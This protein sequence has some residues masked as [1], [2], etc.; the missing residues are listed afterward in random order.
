LV[1]EKKWQ[2]YPREK[3][4]LLDQLLL[5]RG[6]KTKADVDLFLNPKLE[7]LIPPLKQFPDMPKVLDRIEK[8]IKQ[9]EPMIIYGDFD[10]DGITGTASLWE[11]LYTFG[12]KVT[13]YIPHRVA[14]GYGLH[15]EAIEKFAQD[16]VKVVIS[17][18]CGITALEEADLAKKLG[19]DLIITDHH[20]PQEKL[21]D[22]FATLHT[23]SLCGS[24]VSWKL[25]W[26]LQEK[27]NPNFN[28]EDILKTI[29]LSAIGTI[30]DMVPLVGENR[31]IVTFG[32]E[33]IKNTHRF[34]LQAMLEEASV[35]KENLRT[36]DIS[37]VIAPRLNS[38]GRLESAMDSLR[39][40][41]T[42][43][44]DRARQ[45][46]H[47]VSQTNQERQKILQEN[48]LHAQEL[49]ATQVDNKIIVLWHESY[50]QGV[51]GLIAGRILEQTG[52]PTIVISKDKDQS[53]GSARSIE[54]L[55]IVE[56]IGNFS[57]LLLNHGGHHMAAGLTIAT[58][59]LDKFRDELNKFVNDKYD[60]V[61]LRPT[62]KVDAQ[63]K[64]EEVSLELFDRLEVMK[65]FGIGNPEPLFVLK[66]LEVIEKKLV[67]KTKSHL[68]LT[69]RDTS[70]KYPQI[71][72]AIGFSMGDREVEV[73]EY[74]DIAFTLM[75][76]TFRERKLVLKLKDTKPAQN[77]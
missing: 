68:K 58:E 24:G 10:V 35:R 61:D 13:P 6:L 46:S 36:Y 57:K 3:D 64:T 60:G 23:E 54:G 17:V 70:G 15:S 20:H 34:G 5:N 51:V 38:M 56:T 40:L 11:T 45:L 50:V 7:E 73:G 30:A 48:L 75:D 22:S 44:E 14:E 62:L 4:E 47:R 59:N 25:G 28:K 55:S 29:D 12:A 52:K 49:V 1:I 74:I 71:L 2:V 16:G 37:F 67:G 65:P 72:E 8:A 26:A 42:K 9:E 27:L 39:L 63:L 77:S 76:D 32:L 43:N 66:N 41:L 21:P 31:I 33:Q 19:I 18:D 69:L 53:K